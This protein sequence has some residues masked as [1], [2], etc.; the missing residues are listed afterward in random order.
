MI[1]EYLNNWTAPWSGSLK[2]EN[3]V[4]IYSL[5]ANGKLKFDIIHFWNFPETN[6]TSLP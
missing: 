4:T 3:S 2:K 6:I 5:H 1:D